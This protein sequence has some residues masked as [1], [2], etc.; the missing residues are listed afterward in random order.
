MFVSRNRGKRWSPKSLHRFIH[1]LSCCS[2]RY[3]VCAPP[4]QWDYW[5][6]DLGYLV[7]LWIGWKQI[8]LQLFRRRFSHHHRML[9]PKLIGLRWLDKLHLA[10]TMQ[11]IRSTHASYRCDYCSANPTP[12]RWFFPVFFF[13]K[14]KSTLPLDVSIRLMCTLSLQFLISQT[15]RS[16]YDR[17]LF[18]SAW[19]STWKWMWNAELSVLAIRTI[20][21]IYIR[22]LDDSYFEID[23]LLD[24]DARWL[25]RRE[26]INVAMT[27]KIFAITSLA[28][29]SPAS[30]T[31][32]RSQRPPFVRICE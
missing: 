25:R 2:N 7:R 23:G 17:D 26:R 13:G 6:G 29:R 15:L 8:C 12:D 5:C 3:R 28:T 22:G 9:S 21:Q 31:L 27:K 20:D 30:S 32:W 11:C 14:K 4:R 16:I 24:D 19:T 18:R 10:I 1:A